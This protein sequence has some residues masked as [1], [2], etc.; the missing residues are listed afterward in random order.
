MLGSLQAE[1]PGESGDP[2]ESQFLYQVGLTVLFIPGSALRKY[3]NVCEVH[4]KRS[5]NQYFFYICIAN[6]EV[7]RKFLLIRLE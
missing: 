5:V 7:I 1:W 2:S 4:T 3:V 6:L